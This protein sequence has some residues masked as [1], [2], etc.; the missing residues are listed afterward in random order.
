VTLSSCAD[1]PAKLLVVHAGKPP[2]FAALLGDDRMTL[3]VVTVPAGTSDADLRRVGAVRSGRNIV[4][5]VKD[6]A[7]ER[8][9]WAQHLCR[10]WGSWFE[11]GGRIS[12]PSISKAAP[13][14]VA[15][16]RPYL[17]VVVPAHNA[18]A[19]L[20]RT[21]EAIAQSDLPRVLWE[22]VVVDD[23]STDDSAL[24]AAQYA[25]KLVRLPDGPHGPGYVRN[26]GFEMTLGVCVAF[27]NADVMVRPNTLSRFYN[28]LKREPDV[29][30]VFGSYDARSST[31]G[32]VSQYQNLLQHYHHQ[33]NGGEASTFWSACGAVR[34][35]AFEQAGCFDEWH[36]RRR[37]LEDLELGQ[38]I[39]LM[40]HRVL[41]RPEIQVTHLKQWTLGGIIAKE[42]F[43]RGIPWMRLVNRALAPTKTSPRSLRSTKKLNIALTWFGA[44]LSALSLRPTAQLFRAGA[45][46][47]FA[48]VVINDWPRLSLFR[49]ERGLAFAIKTIAFDLLYYLVGGVAM[50]VGWV[51]QHA[52]GEPHPNA[53][54]EAFAELDVKTWP[55]VPSKRRPTPSAGNAVMETRS[56]MAFSRLRREKTDATELNLQDI[57]PVIDIPPDATL[58]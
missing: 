53:A 36:F 23:G 51:L 3:T 6:R 28:V 26:R 13:L 22:L 14:D 29:G 12:L 56:D 2:D 49:R 27:V 32:F 24:I 1:E 45:L 54:T 58:H 39:R 9:V 48:V 16:S 35:A 38:R 43:D 19:T 4:A 31:R 46:A 42:I 57:P 30:A 55:P 10:G 21:L 7:R 52:V 34:S 44:V 47:C 50:L 25:D 15:W 40:G 8:I 17:S 18:A 37:Q 33:R 41:L 11:R 5:F 20:G